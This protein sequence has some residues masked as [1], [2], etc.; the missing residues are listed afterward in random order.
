[1][2]KSFFEDSEIFGAPGLRPHLGID[3]GDMVSRLIVENK[4]T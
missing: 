2:L 4:L 3:R 1:M